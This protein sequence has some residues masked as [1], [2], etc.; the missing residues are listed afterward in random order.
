MT[1]LDQ[2]VVD[3]LGL[4]LTQATLQRFVV[5]DGRFILGHVLDTSS[6]IGPRRFRAPVAFSSQLHVGFNLLGRRG[7]FERFE[8]V[9]FQERRRQLVFRFT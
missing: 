4:S 5:G 8:E 3:A 7:V 2:A 9:A 6:Q 1:I